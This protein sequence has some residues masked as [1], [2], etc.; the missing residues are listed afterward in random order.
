MAEIAEMV[1]HARWI[2]C[3]LVID[4]RSQGRARPWPMPHAP[5]RG[6]SGLLATAGR[7]GRSVDA[8]RRAEAQA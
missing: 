3:G 2:C 1:A 7:V 6:Q 5:R 8:P 4:G